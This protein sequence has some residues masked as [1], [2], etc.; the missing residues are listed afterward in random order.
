MQVASLIARD[1]LL[2]ARGGIFDRPAYFARRPQDEAELDVGPVSGAETAADVVADKPQSF[3]RDPQH[4]G[5]LQP[6]THH[7]RTAGG[8]VERVTRR[9]LVVASKPRP[10]L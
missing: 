7:A 5:E 3:R 2:R 9:V 6:L 4:G 1:H 8:E 10:W